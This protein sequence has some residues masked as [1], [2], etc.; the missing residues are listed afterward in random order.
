MDRI[1]CL[2]DARR[3]RAVLA[4]RGRVEG[5]QLRHRDGAHASEPDCT[6]DAGSACTVHGWRSCM[7]T[8]APGRSPAITSARH[9]SRRRL[10]MVVARHDRPEH[11]DEPER[12]RDLVGSRVVLLVGRPEQPRPPA[13]LLLHQRLRAS[14]LEPRHPA[15]DLGE[16][17]VRPRVV[18]DDPELGLG[19]RDVRPFGE[20]VAD[21]EEG[22]VRSAA[23][24]VSS[25][26][27]VRGPGPS[28]KVSATAFER[29]APQ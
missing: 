23:R 25:N 4:G 14:E 28:S 26:S 22:R 1:L 8:I 3:E 18:A 16:P 27:P 12:P 7:S 6:Q 10:R 21:E 2:V 17:R 13:E 5:E 19:P 11:L 20:A 29:P 9:R 24:N 15:R